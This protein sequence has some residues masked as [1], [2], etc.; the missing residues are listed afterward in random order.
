MTEQPWDSRPDETTAPPKPLI[1]TNAHADW[2][3]LP[4]Q[5]FGELARLNAPDPELF[6]RGIALVRVRTEEDDRPLIEPMTEA[7]LKGI[8]DNFAKSFV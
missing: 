3:E 6:Q 8:L 2:H 4:E 1:V 5:A 7:S